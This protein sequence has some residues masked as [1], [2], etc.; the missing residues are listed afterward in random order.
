M[1]IRGITQIPTISGGIS[2]PYTRMRFP[3]IN[4]DDIYTVIHRLVH[5]GGMTFNEAKSVTLD[6]ATKYNKVIND[7]IEKENDA[8]QKARGKQ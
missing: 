5:D 7:R 3:I 6:Q 1:F 4:E 2:A 8:I